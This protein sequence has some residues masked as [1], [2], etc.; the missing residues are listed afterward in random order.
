MKCTQVKLNAQLTLF[1]KDGF[2]L[3]HIFALY[4]GFSEAEIMEGSMSPVEDIQTH[5]EC[6]LPLAIVSILQDSQT[7]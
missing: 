7:N 3:Y 5:R 4:F 6:L 2:A 1:I